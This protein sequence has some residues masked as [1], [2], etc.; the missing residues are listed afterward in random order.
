[1]AYRLAVMAGRLDVKR[2]LRQIPAKEFQGWL[3]YYS[4]EPFGAW[5]DNYHTALLG[6]LVADVAGAK[7]T[8]ESRFSLDDFMYKV[9]EPVKKQTVQEQIAIAKIIA[10]AF[11]AKGVNT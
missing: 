10:M 9:Q 3:R 1:M 11:N 6:K 2:M 7:K 5:R 4:I 8:D